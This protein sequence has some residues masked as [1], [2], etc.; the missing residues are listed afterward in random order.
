MWNKTWWDVMDLIDNPKATFEDRRRG[1]EIVAGSEMPAEV[2]AA[3]G[4]LM[5]ELDA[6]EK[7]L[8]GLTRAVGPN[9]DTVMRPVG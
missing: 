1:L 2:A 7:K 8:K 9:A 5:L 6:L 3:A 4:Q